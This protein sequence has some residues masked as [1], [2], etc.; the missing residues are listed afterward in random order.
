MMK[1][2]TKVLGV[3]FKTHVSCLKKMEGKG[4]PQKVE[5]KMAEIGYPIKFKETQTFKYYPVGLADLVII[6]AKEIFQWQKEDIFKMGEMSP[7][8]SFIAKIIMK[9]FL[10]L[11]QCFKS[12][13]VYW[14]KHFTKG[15]VE[16]YLLDKEHKKVILRLKAT[17]TRPEICAFYAGYFLRI[18]KFVILS[19]K[20]TIK[21]T[22]CTF[23][24]DP[25]HEFTIT[26]E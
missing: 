14:R 26:W 12:A 15:T 24:G 18:A 8:Y 5:E 11:K 1:N 13:P 23:R 20:A 21:E 17:V 6:V 9:Y 7:Q 3:V 19:K 25:F 22:K 2:P 16:P 4:A 10:S